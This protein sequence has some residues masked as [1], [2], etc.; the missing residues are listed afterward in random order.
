M[1]Q[2]IDTPI[3]TNDLSLDRVTQAGLPVALIFYSKEM[4]ASLD[5]SMKALA[6]EYA[7]LILIVKIKLLT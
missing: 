7:G 5:Q 3:T 6:Q 1:T 2:K 4:P